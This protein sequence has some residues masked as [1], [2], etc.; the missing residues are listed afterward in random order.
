MDGKYDSWY[1]DSSSNHAMGA[2]ALVILFDQ[3]TRNIYRNKP[4]SFSNDEKAREIARYA[5]DH[6]F[7]KDIIPIGRAFLYLPFL[8]SED[9]NDQKIS[10]D[11]FNLLEAEFGGKVP[12]IFN[13]FA[14]LARSKK[15]EI[16]TYGRFPKRNAILGR[17][18]TQKEE[19]DYSFS[20]LK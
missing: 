10:V 3:F 11:L 16:E 2:L 14:N 20:F 15:K 17:K 8:H 9:P 13:R 5:I 4:M 6:G 1:L 18:N 12:L 19:E 7:D